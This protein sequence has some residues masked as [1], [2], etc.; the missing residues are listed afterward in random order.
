[1]RFLRIMNM[2]MMNKGMKRRNLSFLNWG[3][4]EKRNFV[5]IEVWLFFIMFLVVLIVLGRKIQFIF[6]MKCKELD[7]LIYM[8]VKDINVLGR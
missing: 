1:M 7:Y 6:Q 5:I 3:N 8:R 4:L 2:Q